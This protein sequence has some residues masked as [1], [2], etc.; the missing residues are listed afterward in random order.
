MSEWINFFFQRP[1]QISLRNS[2]AKTAIRQRITL[3]YLCLVKRNLAICQP[4]NEIINAT[5][6]Q[7]WTTEIFYVNDLADKTEKFH[8]R[9]CHKSKNRFDVP[10]PSKTQLSAC[11]EI[12]HNRQ[13]LNGNSKPYFDWR[14]VSFAQVCPLKDSVVKLGCFLLIK[15]RFAYNFR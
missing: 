6:Q 4:W 1:R 8:G 5:P 12:G 2:T 13:K 9:N 3:M 15:S 14:K 7:N 11:S 10:V